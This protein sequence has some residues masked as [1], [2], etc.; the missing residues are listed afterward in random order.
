V[1]ANKPKPKAIGPYV[2]KN[3]QSQ[4]Q[5][6]KGSHLL[7]SGVSSTPQTRAAKL[8][9][10]DTKRREGRNVHNQAGQTHTGQA[11]QENYFSQG[12]SRE[13]KA[14]KASKPQKQ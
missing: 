4:A 7:S 3:A 14:T 6:A 12:R 8:Q 5:F 2:S 1:N 10:S 13:G 11:H 9:K